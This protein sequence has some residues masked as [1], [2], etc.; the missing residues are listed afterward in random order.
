MKLNKKHKNILNSYLNSLGYKDK[1]WHICVH[2]RSEDFYNEKN[3]TAQ[4]FRNSPIED[5]YLL[6]K[7]IT[8]LGGWVFRMGDSSMPKVDK[9]YFKNNANKIID[10]ANSKFKNDVLDV[11][12]CATCKLFVSSPSGLHTVAHSFGKPH[13]T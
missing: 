4:S 2:V 11:A 5:Y 8:D 1:D 12:I 6:F 10:Y 3:N 7:K 13:V 9:S